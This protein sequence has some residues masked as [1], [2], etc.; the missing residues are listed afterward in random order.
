MFSRYGD[1]SHVKFLNSISVYFGEITR[2]GSLF[3]YS[4][5]LESRKVGGKTKRGE[6]VM[7]GAVGRRDR[8]Q[9]RRDE[10]A[11]GGNAGVGIAGS[12]ALTAWAGYEGTWH[13]SN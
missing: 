10:A 7:Q 6:N 1:K 5:C 8:S 11:A 13:D 3:S 2:L 4:T 12:S 9:L